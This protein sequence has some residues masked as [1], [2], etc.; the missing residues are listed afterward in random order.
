MVN[1]EMAMIRNIVRLIV[2]ALTVV[3]A[4]L[5]AAAQAS[6]GIG[7]RG[8]WEIVVRTPDGAVTARR[9]FRNALTDSGKELLTKLL[10]GTPLTP[11]LLIELAGSIFTY[12]GY[13]M[14]SGTIRPAPCPSYYHDPSREDNSNFTEF[15]GLTMTTSGGSIVLSGSATAGRTGSITAVKTQFDFSSS[16]TETMLKDSAGAPLPLEVEAGQI[17][18]VRVTIS[19]LTG[20]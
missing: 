2:L 19:F 12:S 6:E 5:T 17:V 10:T 1:G 3:A 7:V 15:C 18:Q 16:F 14:T 4:P 8:E 11:R 9:E 13:G 20:A